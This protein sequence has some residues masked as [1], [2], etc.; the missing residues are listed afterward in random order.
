[1]H[2]PGET[3]PINKQATLN[4]SLADL[5]P[6]LADADYTD[7]RASEDTGL[8]KGTGGLSL[9]FYHAYLFTANERYLELSLQFF[10]K[11]FAAMRYDNFCLSHGATGAMWILNFFKKEQVIEMPFEQYLS[12]YDELLYKVIDQY[13]E[14]IDPMHGLLSIANYLLERNSATASKGL[15]KIVSILDE[16]KV[17]VEN[18]IAWE[19]SRDDAE[20]GTYRH[21]N[22]GY[23]HGVPAILYFLSRLVHA[24]I[25]EDKCRQLVTRGLQFFLSLQDFKEDN[26]FPSRIQGNITR[27]CEKLAYCYSDLG[28]ACGLT[29]IARNLKDTALMSTAKNVAGHVAEVSLNMSSYFPDIGLCHGTS[30]NGYMFHKLFQVHQLDIL[31]E[32]AES[33]FRKLLAL[34]N[35]DLGISGFTAIDFNKEKGMFIRTTEAGF[36]EGTAGMGLAIIAYLNSDLNKDW[37]RILYLS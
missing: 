32:A 16:K 25:E 30:G 34:R 3:Y 22:L 1:M 11:S 12:P 17:L 24:K 33:Q 21:I 19:L 29:A 31:R 15:E 27:K 6:D 36:I 5:I 26:Y 37:E 20:A 4:K 9:F 13:R 10:E 7:T 28:I 8:F 14:N 35:M 18:G 23:A 2:L